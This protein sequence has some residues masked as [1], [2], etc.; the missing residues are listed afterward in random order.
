MLDIKPTEFRKAPLPPRALLV[1]DEAVIALDMTDILQDAG[2]IDIRVATTAEQGLAL[3][4]EGVV[5][6]AIL[7]VNLGT[8]TS[9]GIARALAEKRVP[10]V[11]TTGCNHGSGEMSAFPPSPVLQKPYSPDDIIEAIAGLFTR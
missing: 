9:L 10:F 7:D 6:F 5:D 8:T 2:V 3:L 1:E 4:E 11:L